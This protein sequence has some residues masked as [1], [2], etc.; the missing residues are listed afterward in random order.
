MYKK[1][2]V[3]TVIICDRISDGRWQNNF[4]LTSYLFLVAIQEFVKSLMWKKFSYRA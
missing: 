2:L 3:F 4:K 1:T